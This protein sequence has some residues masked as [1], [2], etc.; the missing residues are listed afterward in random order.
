MTAHRSRLIRPSSGPV[1]HERR[2]VLAVCD[3]EGRP[4]RGRNSA[5]AVLRLEHMTE[6]T[7]MRIDK[8]LWA[9]RFFKSRTIA[10]AACD[11]GKVD[12]NDQAVKPSR[13]V[14]P[15]DRLTI[16]LPR[17]KRIVRV[18][19]LSEQ[20]SARDGG[21]SALRRLDATATAPRV[22]AG[23]GGVSSA[24]CRAPDQARA[25]SDRPLAAVTA[26]ERGAAVPAYHPGVCAIRRHRC[27]APRASSRASARH[28]SRAALAL[29]LLSTG[30][31]RMPTLGRTCPTGRRHTWR[32][33]GPRSMG[34]S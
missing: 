21:R 30:W 29:Q 5:P 31:T 12:L 3:G 25:P 27:A 9:A 17:I 19:A 24:R 34:R 6:L 15:G 16:G 20:R 13:P 32:T 23:P 14:R 26:R 7:E 33:G 2:R 11:G 1:S 22:A 8:W 4:L 28:C 18:V 10:A